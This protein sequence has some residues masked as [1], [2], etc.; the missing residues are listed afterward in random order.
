MSI[1]KLIKEAKE[2]KLR[3]FDYYNLQIR[4]MINDVYSQNYL[5]LNNHTPK[6]QK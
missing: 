3:I 4:I 5:I 2:K 1:I 6:P